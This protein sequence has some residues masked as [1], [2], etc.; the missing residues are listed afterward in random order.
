[1]MRKIVRGLV[2]VCALLSVLVSAQTSEDTIRNAPWFERETAPG[3]KWRQYHFDSLYNSQQDIF[4]TMIDLNT[5]GIQVSFPFEHLT[6]RKKVSTF[7]S[8]LPNAAALING[9]FCTLAVSFSSSVQ[10]LKVDGVLINE[11]VVGAADE[12]GILIHTGKN[13]VEVR[14]R[15]EFIP[16]TWA[17]TTTPNVMAT[18][19]MIVQNGADYP[20]PD[21]A[22]YTTDRHPRTVVGITTT[23][24]LLL[25]VI[26]G[27]STVAAGQT[28]LEMQKTLRALGAYDAVNMDGGGSSTL[29][30]R[31]ELKNGVMNIPSD[32]S[33]RLVA[34]AVAVSINSTSPRLDWDARFLRSSYSNTM[35]GGSTQTVWMEFVNF[36]TQSWNSTI[37]LATTETT[38]RISPFYMA[39]D[40]ISNKVPG[41]ADASLVLTGATAR[42][43]FSLVAPN[44]TIQ[45]DYT[46]SFGVFDTTG[47]GISQLQNRMNITVLPFSAN[48]GPIIIESRSGGQNVGW[49]TDSG[50]ADS[51]TN[52]TAP[53]VT[54][55]IG[56]RYGSTYKSVA[57]VKKAFFTPVI[58]YAGKYRVYATWGAGA[59]RRS[60]ITYKVTHSTGSTQI[61]LDQSSTANVWIDLGEYT[62]TAGNTGFL[63]VNN[64]NVDLS[65]SMYISAAKFEP[66]PAPIHDWKKY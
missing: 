16:G 36:G 5:P 4:Y 23:N 42:F 21:I 57:G 43:T 30:L 58:S 54:S 34:N 31:N 64:E 9:N 22:F 61:L 52:C 41:G 18:N 25:V 60:P 11:T 38:N 59:N 17:S 3:I 56:S 45:K 39:G 51:G 26:D 35:F 1:M 46:E 63:E 37:R 33:E 19:V 20:L 65:G 47:N 50:M 12:G 7:A 32:G 53:G 49:Y 14:H 44:D 24:Q 66:V 2:V 13:K 62:F 28:F 27:R 55:T 15:E 10:Y 8:E 40:W 48:T 6:S 29:W